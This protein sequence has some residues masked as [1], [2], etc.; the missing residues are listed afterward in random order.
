MIKGSY[1]VEAKIEM[2]VFRFDNKE[3]FQGKILTYDERGILIKN[4][5]TKFFIKKEDLFKGSEFDK[6]KNIFY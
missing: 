4:R 5:N 6:E 1:I 2:K 3:D